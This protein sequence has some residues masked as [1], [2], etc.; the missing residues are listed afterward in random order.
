[1]QF[2]DVKVERNDNAHKRRN[3]KSNK[4]SFTDGGKHGEPEG[5][6]QSLDSANIAGLRTVVQDRSRRPAASKAKE[7]IRILDFLESG[8]FQRYF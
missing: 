5:I 1:M 7:M 8:I 6:K 3:G 4:P 2:L